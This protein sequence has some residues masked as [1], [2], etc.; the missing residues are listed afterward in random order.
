MAIVNFQQ[1]VWSKKIQKQLETITSLKDHCDFQYEGDAKMA[2]RVKIVGVARPTIRTYT[3][4]SDITIEKG[5]D[6][7]Q[8]I[9]ID[10]YDYFAFEVEDIDK[11]Q[12]IPGL[13]EALSSEATIAL[14][15][16]ADK[17]VADVIDGA[18]ADLNQVK[19]DVS[20]ATDGGISVI[21]S[22]LE[23]LYTSNVRP[24]ETLWLEITPSWFTVLRP[25]IIMIDTNNSELIKTGAVGKYGNCLITIEN[26]LK[27]NVT[28]ANQSG[29]TE[30]I[31]RS[32]KAVAFIGQIDKVEAF[33]PEGRFTDALKGLYVYGAKV[34]RPEQI[35][36]IGTY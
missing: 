35:C 27:T 20:A 15:E 11:A 14:A 9:N 16:Q 25:A 1:T 32:N 30:N 28:I 29:C 24:S 26:N 3:P 8:F 13:I 2:E 6:T 4:G 22:A 31:I 33:R 12:S 5:V 21:E 36:L 18:K 23:K 7:S 10:Q 34:V 17:Y 19:L